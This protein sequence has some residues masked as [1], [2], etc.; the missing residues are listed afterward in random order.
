[1]R[2][3]ETN[4]QIR[5]FLL[6]TA[7]AV[8][9]A[10]IVRAPKDSDPGPWLAAALGLLLLRRTVI[11]A[12]QSAAVIVSGWI[13]TAIIIGGNHGFLDVNKPVW[14]GLTIVAGVGFAFWERIEKLWK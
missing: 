10:E 11:T 9:L 4:T 8:C 14:I 12:P 13:L 3:E 2:N 7:S 5:R 6:G 1:M